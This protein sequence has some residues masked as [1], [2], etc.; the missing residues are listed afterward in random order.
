VVFNVIDC[1]I[2]EI[3]IRLA[4]LLGKI[5]WELKRCDLNLRHREKLCDF[6]SKICVDKE[7][8]M[9]RSAAFNLPCFFKVY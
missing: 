4:R 3:I 2:E 8:D 9:R 6:Y 1:N 5:V 7:I